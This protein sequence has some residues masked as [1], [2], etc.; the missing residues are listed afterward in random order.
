VAEA[1]RRQEPARDL[2]IVVGRRNLRGG[3]RREQRDPD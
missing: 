3:D 2:R 1:G